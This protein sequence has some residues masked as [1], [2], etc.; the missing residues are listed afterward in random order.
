MGTSGKYDFEDCVWMTHG[1]PEEII[2]NYKIY[3]NGHIIPLW[4][5]KPADLIPY[6]PY[7]VVFEAFEKDKKCGVMHLS[8]RS[9]I[10]IE[11]EENLISKLNN[12]KRYW[13]KCKRIKKEFDYDECLEM[14]A[15]GELPKDDEKEIVRRVE[16]YGDKAT[17]EGIHDERHDNMRQQLYQAMVDNGWNEPRAYEWFFGFDRFLKREINKD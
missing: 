1:S 8:S 10:D 17:I 12:A 2:K 7:L 11:E 9:F 15:W 13:R 14:V 4:F 3:G 5:Q 16:K 6:Y